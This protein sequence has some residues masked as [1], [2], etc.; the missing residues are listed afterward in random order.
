MKS[1]VAFLRLVG[2]RR[3]D[4]EAPVPD[5]GDALARRALR[6]AGIGDLA[7]HLRLLGIVDH[8]R[9]GM[10]IDVSA[11]GS[12]REGVGDV[13]PVPV[14]RRR[15]R[16]LAHQVDIPGQRRLRLGPVDGETAVLEPL[17]AEL[18]EDRRIDVD[19]LAGAGD[20]AKGGAPDAGVRIV[21]RRGIGHESLQILRGL[22]PLRVVEIL[23]VDLQGHLAVIGHAEQLAVD[24]VGIAPGRDDVV[25]LEPVRIR[26]RR[27]GEVS[28]H[29]LDPFVGCIQ[30]VI[31]WVGGM[32]GVGA[33]LR[34]QVDHA[35]L[36]DLG[37][38]NL[39]EPHRDARERLE[40]RREG[41]QVVEIGRRN[42]GNRDGFALE[43]LPVDLC[44]LVG[45]E[46]SL[47][48]QRAVQKG[49]SRSQGGRRGDTRFQKGAPSEFRILHVLP[50]VTVL[51]S[52]F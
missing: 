45:G 47:L 44:R 2:Q 8:G 29:R 36:A 20:A 39:L 31:H 51:I 38:R 24:A 13:G 4:R 37:R 43:L 26:Q 46:I 17:A 16:I 11:D 18:A 12:L 7:D 10:G 22:E 33:R 1:Q 41:D 30:R 14:L 27:V 49:R 6:P 19:V 32:G 9:G 23:A 5:R 35:L 42:D 28:L 25:E 21:N 40:L 3:V 34:G 48:R 15:G 52:L 50:P